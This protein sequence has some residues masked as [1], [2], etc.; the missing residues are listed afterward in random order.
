MTIAHDAFIISGMW[1]LVF[2]AIVVFPRLI[3]F[4][5]Q[6]PEVPVVNAE[7]GPCDAKFEVTDGSGR[8]LY[9][10]KVHV[11][12]RHGFMSKRKLDLEVGTNSEGKARVAG[13]PRE[14]KRIPVFRISY[15]GE[16]R[17]VQYDPATNCHASYNIALGKAAAPGPAKE[18]KQ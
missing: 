6:A 18:P 14:L 2:L 17:T 7:L 4:A 15:D 16:S 12:I 1:K 10:A 5:Q 8:P 11:L 9:N 13:L 3:S